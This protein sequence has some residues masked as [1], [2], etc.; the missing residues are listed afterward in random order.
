MRRTW[1]QILIATVVGALLG[2][3][4]GFFLGDPGPTHLAVQV[5]LQ[6]FVASGI[7]LWTAP[8]IARSRAENQAA[9]DRAQEQRKADAQAR[10]A[11]ADEYLRWRGR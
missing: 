4:A 1:V 11:E 5:G 6:F 9:Y 8:A 3:V 2:G 10:Q 7:G